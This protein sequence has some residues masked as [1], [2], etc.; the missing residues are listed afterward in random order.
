MG[1]SKRYLNTNTEPAPFSAEKLADAI[2]EKL[3]AVLFAC[4][5]G[6]SAETFVV[7]PYSD[8]DIALYLSEKPSLS[9]F[10]TLQEICEEIVGPV[11]VDA[12]ILNNTEPVYR[13]EAIKGHLLFTRDL[14]TW[15]KFFSVTCREYETQMFHYEKQRRYRLE[16]ER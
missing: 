7:K 11:R 2:R 13:F 10:S 9:F 16:A 14:E 12:G 1:L 6:S 3:P 5:F 4:I 8:L 15:L